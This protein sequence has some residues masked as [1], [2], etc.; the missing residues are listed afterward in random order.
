MLTLTV[1]GA[2]H[3]RSP[4]LGAVRRFIHVLEQN[5]SD[6][7]EEAEVLRLRE[8][9]AKRIRASQQ[10]EGDLS[11]M[12]IQIGLLVRNRVTLQVG[13]GEDGVMASVCLNGLP[14]GA[15]CLEVVG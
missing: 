12:D 2:V 11:L 8:E 3:E 1:P 14:G 5:Q 6:F 9:V 4:P 13:G 7:V 10:L 15:L